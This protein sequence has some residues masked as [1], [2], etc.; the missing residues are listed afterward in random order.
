LRFIQAH[1]ERKLAW[2][3]FAEIAIG[4]AFGIHL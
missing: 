2:R 4:V 3:G 1:E